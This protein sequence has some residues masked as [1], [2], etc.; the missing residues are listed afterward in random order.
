[1]FQFSIIC[2]SIY[3]KMEVI[4]IYLQIFQA[5][6]RL[7]ATMRHTYYHND[8]KLYQALLKVLEP[9]MGDD[10][11]NRSVTLS[12]KQLQNGKEDY[13]F[14]SPPGFGIHYI[15]Y[16]SHWVRIERRQQPELVCDK[17]PFE[18]ITLSTYKWNKHLLYE[19][20]TEAKESQ[21]D[22]DEKKTA[23]YC[24]SCSDWN[25]F[26]QPKRRRLLDSVITAGRVKEMLLKDVNEFLD[27][28]DWYMD[29]GIP[30]RRGYL[31]HGPPGTGKSSL[32]RAIAGEI[33]YDICILSL[34]AKD[35]TDDELNRL[36]NST[37][38]KC[39]ILLEDVDAAFKSREGED[40]GNGTS[41]LAYEGAGASKVTFRGLLNSLDGVASTEGRILFITTNHIN[42]LDPALIRPGRVD[43]RIHV[44][45]PTANQI[46]KM[47]KRF[48]PKASDD[49]ADTFLHVLMGMDKKI[50]MAAIQGKGFLKAV[51]ISWIFR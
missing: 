46:T 9:Y 37:P 51:S 33:G 19:L 15:Q 10:F 41:H 8:D 11:K 5:E 29:R 26:G 20:L 35:L 2:F 7:A 32:I 28:E 24:I 39:I 3:E 6:I 34:S 23:F 48:Y 14:I 12:S 50:S 45:Y 21:R 25:S 31:L 36:M 38:D 44:D 22:H 40:N 47:F 18:F 17:V 4:I 13:E 27:S 42:K 43:I 16:K 1:M 49:L 30:Y